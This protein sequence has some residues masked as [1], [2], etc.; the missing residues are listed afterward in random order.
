MSRLSIHLDDAAAT[1]R[2]GARLAP[3]LQGGMTVTVQG[4]LGS[5]K[6]TLVRGLLRARGVTGSI[7]SPTYTLVEHYPISSLYF[8]HFDFYRF[9]SPSEWDD[10]GLSDH[11]RDDSVCIVEWPE[12]V[13]GLL[14]APDLALSLSYGARG[15]GRELAV[16]SFSAA[17][18]RC[19][20]ALAADP[21]RP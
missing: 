1:E 15:A 18:E 9:M 8:Y 21:P 6:T 11:F 16:E 5:G 17:G 2:A 14:P 13:A 4:E 10:S 3:P 19:V 20:S 12:R 7:K